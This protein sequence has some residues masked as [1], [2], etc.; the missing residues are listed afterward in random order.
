MF[1]YETNYRGGARVFAIDQNFDGVADLITAP[2][3]GRPPTVNTYT[4][5]GTTLRP[6]GAS[7]NAFDPAF[8][9]GV[10]VG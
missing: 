1:P 4:L 5:A 6:L 7:F 9:G 10:F 3:P 8:L 2:G